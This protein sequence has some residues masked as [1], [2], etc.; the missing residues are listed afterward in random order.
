MKFLTE[1]HTSAAIKDIFA[2][3]DTIRIAVAFWGDGALK[4][5]GGLTGATETVRVLCNF[6]SG[7]CNPA[8]VERLLAVAEVKSHPKLHAKVYWTPEAM[9]LGSSNASTNG[10]WGEADETRGWREANLLITDGAQLDATEDWFDQLWD[11]GYDVTKAH[12]EA[13]KPL[14][15]ARK[16]LAPTGKRLALTLFDAFRSAPDDP[17]WDRVKVAVTTQDLSV[18]GRKEYDSEVSSVKVLEDAAAYEDW[19]DRFST[20][21]LVID[22][23]QIGKKQAEVSFLTTGSKLLQSSTL[24]Y[25]WPIEKLDI[26]HLGRFGLTEIELKALR[27]LVCIVMQKVAARTAG[28]DL[29]PLK[30]AMSLIGGES[31]RPAKIHLLC[32]ANEGLRC[33]DKATAT[34]E[35]EAWL[36]SSDDV[37]ALEGGEVFLHTAKSQPSYFGGRIK[38]V[39][40]L[41]D[42]STSGRRRC[43]LIIESRAE[44]KGVR[45]DKRGQTHGMAWTTGVVLGDA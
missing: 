23:D 28:G 38:D 36:L 35:S 41:Q 42:G 18:E 34:Y 40:P 10:L 3:A 29:M 7:A 30:E 16:H 21:D 2:D 11:E 37:A 43:A 4:M 15:A 31:K 33:T 5:L 32:R 26:A 44:C 19:N 17:V 14:W 27:S 12:I 6:D 1:H 45:W 39:R 22:I 9:V 20:D 25:L 8:E 24:T 13:A